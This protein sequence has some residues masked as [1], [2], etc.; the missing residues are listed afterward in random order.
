MLAALPLAAAA[1]RIATVVPLENAGSE[2]KAAAATAPFDASA[3]VASVWQSEVVRVL[4]AA[5]DAVAAARGSAPASAGPLVV[6]GRGRVVDIDTRSRSGTATL[7]LDGDPNAR[8]VLQIGPVLTGNAVR[9]AIPALGFDR[10][11][12][13]IQHADVGNALNARLEREVL[14]GLDRERLRGRRLSFAGMAVAEPN[15]LLV[16][17]VRLEVDGRP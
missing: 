15:R 13:Q 1:C 9:D 2:G 8:V 17:P 16:T 11:V 14:A 7:Q 5:Q 3:H 6:R 4:D 12:N 10:F